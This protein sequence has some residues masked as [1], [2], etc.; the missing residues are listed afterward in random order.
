MARDM[1]E[2][3]VM[4][5]ADSFRHEFEASLRAKLLDIATAEI[6]HIVRE[7]SRKVT[8]Q[9]SL[10]YSNM[11]RAYSMDYRVKVTQ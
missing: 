5:A 2:H 9:V 1:A 8:T 7:V 6:E 11:D 10:E 3:V 4:A